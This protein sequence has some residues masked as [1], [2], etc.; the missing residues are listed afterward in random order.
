MESTYLKAE[1]CDLATRT[2]IKTIS[3]GAKA[4]D[5]VY[6][7]ANR[8]CSA[9][10]PDPR[11]RVWHSG[12]SAPCSGSSPVRCHVPGHG[13]KD[14]TGAGTGDRTRDGW[15][16]RSVG[17]SCRVSL[18]NEHLSRDL[19]AAKGHAVKTSRDGRK[20]SWAAGFLEGGQRQGGLA[21]A[22]HFRGSRREPSRHQYR[23]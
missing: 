15:D 3:I 2:P 1:L 6:P 22:S 17:R 23:S 5:F 18:S 19:R 11:H 9:Q 12:L 4:T 14:G 8:G 21:S 20:Y 13:L 16:N 10:L 7:S